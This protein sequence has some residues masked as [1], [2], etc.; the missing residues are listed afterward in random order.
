VPEGDHTEPEL[1]DLNGRLL[2]TLRRD[3]P[4]APSSTRVGGRYALRPCYVNPR[5][6]EADVDG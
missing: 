4:Y 6:T 3:T 2:R 1:D 5:T